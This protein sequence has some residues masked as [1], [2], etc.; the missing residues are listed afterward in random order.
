MEIAE[1]ALPKH[2]LII[3]VECKRQKEKV[4]IDVAGEIFNLTFDGE[5]CPDIGIVH[6]HIFRK[7]IEWLKHRPGDGQGSGKMGFTLD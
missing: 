1:G 2:N 4:A 7:I 3:P 6:E 5:S